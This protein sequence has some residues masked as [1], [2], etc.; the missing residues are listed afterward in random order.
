MN[1]RMVL[2]FP[3]E[4]IVNSHSDRASAAAM[5]RTAAESKI[6]LAWSTVMPQSWTISLSIGLNFGG[7][8]LWIVVSSNRCAWKVCLIVPWQLVVMNLLMSLTV[9]EEMGNRRKIL[10]WWPL[11]A[12]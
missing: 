10:V 12:F 8:R 1:R 11:H 7:S 5:R 4:G 2:R 3:P 9:V 6:A